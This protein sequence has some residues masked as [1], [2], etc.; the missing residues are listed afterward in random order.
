MQYVWE[1]RLWP[2]SAMRTVDGQVIRVIDPGRINH[3]A[4]PDFFNAKVWIDGHLWAGNVEIHV[5]A[6]DW[7]RHRHDKDAAYDSVIL[8]VVDKDDAIVRRSNGEVIPQMRMPCSPDLNAKYTELVGRADRDLPCAT[9][10]QSFPTIYLTDWLSALAYERLY[11]KADRIAEMLQRFSGDWE[12]VCYITVA[13][14]LGFGINGE[15]FQRL[16]QSLPLAFMGKHSDSATA[17]EALL[18]G[19]SGLLDG[20]KD[21]YAERL[22]KE[23]VFLAHKFG[24][25]RP[26]GLGW[27][28][29]RMRP[30]NFPHRRIAVLAAMTY[31]GFRMMQRIVETDDVD[32]A[33]ELFIPQLTG[34]WENRYTFGP[35]GERRLTSMSRQSAAVMVVNVAIPLMY[36]YGHQH[37][38]DEL[39]DRAIT[40]LQTLQAEKNSIT[41][42]FG[43]AGVRVRD[44]FHSQALVQLRRNYCEK[45]KC[46]FCRIGHRLLATN[47]RR[48][49]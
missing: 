31:G 42:L 14:A 11:E 29:M 21:E 2:S 46:L 17:I 48:A 40:M 36:A 1:H 20:V 6:S 39:C 41:E 23:Y 16:A 8:H 37:G 27:K 26:E 28:M 9:T 15:P 47:A 32:K 7:R 44:A 4:G 13:R 10:L 18:F 35:G 12:Q 19:Q 22:R 25:R 45:R 38:D 30:A 49:N 24:L 33:I 43:R 34:Y 3:D 5:K